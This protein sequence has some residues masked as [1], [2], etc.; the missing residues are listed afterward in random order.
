MDSLI[1]FGLPFV[2]VDAPTL[3]GS[4]R[5]SEDE[6]IELLKPLEQQ[7]EDED[8]VEV[9]GTTGEN[10]I[11]DYPHPR[12]CC[13]IKP[14]KAGDVAMCRETCPKCCCY[15]CDAPASECRAWET[16]CVATRKS[17]RW[18]AERERIKR[19]GSDPRHHHQQQQ[20]QHHHQVARRREATRSTN[21]AILAGLVAQLQLVP[22]VEAPQPP[23][24][25]KLHPVERQ[26]VSLMVGLEL[27]P[28][29]AVRGGVLGEE[30]IECVVALHLT[31]PG[32]S[33]PSDAEWETFRAV[34]VN[35]A[36]TPTPS[37]CLDLNASL[38]IAPAPRVYAWAASLEEIAPRLR[39]CVYRK[40][41]LLQ[42]DLRDVDILV[43]PVTLELPRFVATH[44]RFRRIF[45][46]QCHV[47]HKAHV[48][49]HRY[50]AHY[51]W[52]LSPTPFASAL[53]PLRRIARSLGRDTPA[54]RSALRAYHVRADPRPLAL[55]LRHWVLRSPTAPPAA[56]TI[57]LPRP[58]QMPPL[59]HPP[60]PR[61]PPIVAPNVQNFFHFLSSSAAN[62]T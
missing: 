27:E 52:A 25:R 62:Q 29:A 20:Q 38:V 32:S 39:V 35:G 28:G 59:A 31:H 49:A 47:G 19:G 61:P 22:M 42:H 3:D 55:I 24:M 51:K 11:T 2:P 46:D 40:H 56:T 6:V 45:V 17:P 50:A 57:N 54:F 13:V 58:Q 4:R 60:L 34:V 1:V 9:V 10:A 26:L 7:D 37:A 41:R 23:G 44:L 53:Q 30:S 8:E 36:P 16:H 18:V 12:E 15:A 43:H 21:A 14:F 5:P 33:R 48:L